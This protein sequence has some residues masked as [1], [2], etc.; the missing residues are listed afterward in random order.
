MT[1]RRRDLIAGG[2][3]LLAAPA[4]R[5]A[6]S[7]LEAV[8]DDGARLGRLRS[9]VVMRGGE[10]V[11][12]RHYGRVRSDDLL[13]LNSVT[14]SVVSM[15]VGA[16]LRDGALPGLHTRVAQLLPEAARRHPGSALGAA[17]LG[18]LLGGRT[19]VDD[20]PGLEDAADGVDFA[21]A[22]PAA[23]A[24]TLPWSYN[25][26]AVALLGPILARA[27][28]ADLEA[29]AERV[30]FRPL[31][32]E[33]WAWP[34]DRQGRPMAWRGLRLRALDMARLAA[35]MADGGRWQGQPLLPADWVTQSLRA[36]GPAT[37]RVDPV[38]DIG[39][40]HL[41]FTGRLPGHDVAWGW[42]YGS[43]FALVVPARQLVVCSFA[44]EPPRAALPAQNRAVMALV[45][46]IVAR[47]A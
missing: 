6:V 42:G 13:P 10:L 2:A 45:A 31:G 4:V 44:I 40:G 18:Q 34:R 3:A 7:D 21:L 29:Y 27:T 8:F 32:I 35:V 11:A 37:W 15:L 9:L 12:A 43:Q 46:R 19:G 28:G 17:T 1:P 47:L 23:P 26:A 38:T 22:L 39:Y 30:L 20:D 36:H 24:G 14:K 33:R 25:D 41:W 5:S 16:A